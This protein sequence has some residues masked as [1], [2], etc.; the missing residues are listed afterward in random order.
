[1]YLW[2]WKSSVYTM[3]VIIHSS[4]KMNK[5]QTS[6]T[7]ILSWKRS[8]H[9]ACF[10][11]GFGQVSVFV[12]CLW[13]CLALSQTSTANQLPVL[14]LNAV[15]IHDHCYS[16]PTIY[17]Y[18]EIYVRQR[19][20]CICLCLSEPALKIGGVGGRMSW[21]IPHWG[22]HTGGSRDLTTDPDPT[23]LF[24]AASSEAFLA[25]EPSRGFFSF[26]SLWWG[27][28]CKL[29]ETWCDP[30][31]SCCCGTPS[32]PRNAMTPPL[33]QLPADSGDVRLPGAGA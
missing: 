32:S 14:A 4:I 9:A 10:G 13:K 12:L 26:L 21:S 16:H 18:I 20:T 28:G 22:K 25:W 8:V 33:L 30:Y 6:G 11:F 17:R 7:V 23:F 3:V 19:L 24:L 2:S 1:M 29:S 27:I 5:V 31:F 15:Y